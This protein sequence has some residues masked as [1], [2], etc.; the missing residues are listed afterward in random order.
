MPHILVT[1]G[2]GVLGREL[3][4]QLQKAGHTARVMS[5]RPRPVN[6]TSEIEWAQAD[7]E[8]GDGLGSAVSGVETIIHTATSPGKRTKQVDVD[9]TRRL[10]EKAREAGVAHFI[11]V[12]IVGIERIP[13]PYYEAKVAGEAVVRGGGVPYT[14]LRATQFHSLLDG[15]F[16]PLR[17]LPL[18]FAFTDFK[19]QPI[20]TGEVADRLCQLVAEKPS[21]LLPDMGGPE[22]WTVGELLPAWF[23]AQGRHCK[24]IRFPLP[25]GFAHAFRNGYNTCPDQRDGNITWA[26]WLRRKYKRN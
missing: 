19:Y 18:S 6:L 4:P 1:G 25:G 24:L 22:V 13:F 9:G 7:I 15:F 2:A 12:S 8:T 23:A 3:T 11:H 10:L 17:N 26:E 20:D 21:G 5:R 14:I 16:Q